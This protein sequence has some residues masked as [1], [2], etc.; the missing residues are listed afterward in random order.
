MTDSPQPHESTEP[1]TGKSVALVAG[2]HV[3]APL[4]G[5]AGGFLVLVYVLLPQLGLGG[6]QR[7]IELGHHLDNRQ[8]RHPAAV[9]LGDSITREGIDGSIVETAAPRGWH[10]E[11]LT[12]SGVSINELKIMLPK[13]LQTHPNLVVLAFGPT[14]LMAADNM[15]VD[16]AYAYAMAGFIDAWP[17]RFPLEDF[18]GLSRES[19]EALFSSTFQQ[20][21]FFRTAPTNWLNG[22]LRAMLRKDIRSDA[23]ADWIRPFA[24]LGPVSGP[25]LAWH[26]DLFKQNLETLPQDVVAQR[27]SGIRH[28][29]AAVSESGATP[30]LTIL[31]V[32]PQLRDDAA[33]I[34][35]DL[36]PL[37]RQ[38][39]QVH[40]GIIVD[41]AD[42]LT[43]EQFADAIHPDTQ[44]REI[45]SLMVGRH[46]PSVEPPLGMSD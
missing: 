41:A 7:I 43:E 46:F 2:L 11:N 35:S 26:I 5:A 19:Y 22:R 16:K 13:V 15:P 40:R 42:I 33:V 44:G 25:A 29:V 10:V 31:P 21:I 9:F 4:L 24:M 18:P 27:T 17:R 37:L 23:E 12:M 39:A 20:R 38:L 28:L 14:N 1:R 45:Y 36:R 30:L 32:H 8:D 34:L 3:A 6:V